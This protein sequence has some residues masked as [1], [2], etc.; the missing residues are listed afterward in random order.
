MATDTGIHWV[1]ALKEYADANRLTVQYYETSVIGSP[2]TPTFTVTVK[3]L[4]DHELEATGI[5]NTKQAAKCK[6]AQALML[7][8]DQVDKTPRSNIPTSECQNLCKDDNA[9]G[10]IIGELQVN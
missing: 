4:C 9:G 2:H 5:G 10:N 8:I 3:L 7:L 1:V 6:A